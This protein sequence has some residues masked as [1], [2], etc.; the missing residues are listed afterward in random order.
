MALQSLAL[1]TGGNAPIAQDGQIEVTL[2]W[3]RALHDVDI[4][5]FLVG[6]NGKVPN[7]DYMVFYNQSADPSRSVQFKQLSNNSISFQIKLDELPSFI[8]KCVFTATIDGQ[9]TF[10]DVEGCALKA[11]SKTTDIR[12]EVNDAKEEK[13]LVVAELYRYKGTFK[14][15]GVGR[16]FNGGLKPLAEAHGVTVE[17]EEETEPETKQQEQTTQK[18]NE[19][20]I[21]LLKKKVAIS[22]QKKN[23]E[24]EKARVAVVIDASGSMTNLFKKGT[25]QRAFE[26]ALAVAAHMDDDGVLDVWFFGDRSMRAQSVTEDDFEDYVKR[27]YPAPKFFRGLGI[28]NNEPAVIKDILKKYTKE[29]PREDMAT[30]VLFFSD[31]GIYKDA[32]ISS[33]LKKASSENIFWQ[34]IGIGK[35]NYGI[36]QKLDDLPGRVVDNA[37]FFPFDDL[38]KVSDEELY[39]RLFN[40]YPVWLQEVK[41]RGMVSS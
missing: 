3:F 16:G 18:I 29:E 4:T 28:G 33:L 30:Y 2:E 25:V 26:R 14:L 17:E 12:Y 19:T 5:C 13:A 34:F 36:L 27:T 11:M 20:K 37:D 21:D 9:S 1:Q 23:I 10:Q 39:N 41:N 15:R 31:G 6:E 35:A 8:E 7:D 22:L 32:E 40:E 24:H 38:D